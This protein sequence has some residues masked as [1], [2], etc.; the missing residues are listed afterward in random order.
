[1]TKH[2]PRPAYETGPW[3][4]KPPPPSRAEHV[5]D[6]SLGWEGFDPIYQRIVDEL[7]A[8]HARIADHVVNRT[9]E[10]F[11]LRLGGVLKTLRNLLIA[12][13]IFMN[14]T[15]GAFA[16]V[17]DN[18]RS[19]ENIV[20]Q[21]Q[22]ETFV[23]R[24]AKQLG[25]VI[26]V[27]MQDISE[28]AFVGRVS[29]AGGTMNENEIAQ[30]NDKL[31]RLHLDYGYNMAIVT[32]KSLNG[33]DIGEYTE[34]LFD[35]WKFSEKKGILLII[36]SDDSK[37][38]L[39]TVNDQYLNDTVRKQVID[40]VDGSSGIFEALN[41]SVDEFIYALSKGQQKTTQQAPKPQQQ[42]FDWDA[43]KR[44]Q[45]TPPQ[46]QKQQD[47]REIDRQAQHRL[48]LEQKKQRDQQEQ[49]RREKLEQ[50]RMAQDQERQEREKPQR[51]QKQRVE[52]S[53][54]EIRTD[55]EKI[56]A[57][58]HTYWQ[59]VQNH[60]PIDAEAMLKQG[61]EIIPLYRAVEAWFKESWQERT[62]A[63]GRIRACISI[64]GNCYQR[65]EFGTVKETM[66]MILHTKMSN[67]QSPKFGRI[68]KNDNEYQI[69]IIYKEPMIFK[70]THVLSPPSNGKLTR[71]TSIFVK[72]RE[73]TDPAKLTDMM[74][75][76]IVMS[77]AQHSETK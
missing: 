37:F 20:P 23:G 66:E 21:E 26:K 39:Y 9:A 43:Y 14:A 71:L 5:E 8:S 67:N 76:L 30:L 7:S 65:G 56:E 57:F 4:G 44:G 45:Q 47:Q 74:N 35:Q 18:I 58:I 72:D 61:E 34:D 75:Y 55:L 29:D 49:E 36:V 10:S 53:M 68:E 28:P 2:T 33:R 54:N 60:T 12:A 3:E 19:V 15:G 24:M 64:I 63:K 13:I 32:L 1:M 38:Y 51:E 70:F 27:G 17:L 59:A 62:I 52:Q 31:Q 46:P 11:G 69:E 42:P 22:R 6:S 41:A 25:L 50:E 16:T 77:R 73:I 40:K 48:E